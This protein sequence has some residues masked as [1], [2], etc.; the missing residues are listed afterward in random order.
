MD[1]KPLHSHTTG[2][3]AYFYL[4]TGSGDPL[5]SVLD[6]TSASATTE[7]LKM[8]DLGSTPSRSLD[9]MSPGVGGGVGGSGGNHDN[10]SLLVSCPPNGRDAIGIDRSED[11]LL[12][13]HLPVERVDDDI[14]SQR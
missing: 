3:A 7:Y 13:H 2:T 11:P 5:A 9:P 12:I 6:P 4:F 8:E 10:A 1:P 14:S